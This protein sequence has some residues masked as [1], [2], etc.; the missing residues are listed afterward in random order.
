ME[1]FISYALLVSVAVFLLY[2][3]GISLAPYKP[4]EIKNEHFE[5]GLP[6]SASTPKKAN[7]G[8]FIYAI[9][10][11]VA[12]MTGLFFTLFVYQDNAHAMITASLFALIIA[13]AIFF[14]TRELHIAQQER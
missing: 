9:M 7:F 11:I 5:C 4:T 10:F 14:A 12:D 6:P 13:M 1:Q 3:F 8:F 2:L